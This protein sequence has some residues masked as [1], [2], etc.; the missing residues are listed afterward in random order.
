MPP[1]TKI[2]LSDKE[3]SLITNSEWI[4]T[5]Q[6]VIQKVYELLAGCSQYIEAAIMDKIF[7]PAEITATTPKIY[8]GENYRQLPY[9]LL[10]YPR[11][12]QQEETFAIRTM[13]WWAN[14]FSITLLVSGK[15]KN[16]INPEALNKTIPW[17]EDLFICVHEDQWQHHF[18]AD[19]YLP[20]H[21]LTKQQQQ[22]LLYSRS[23]IKLSV[24]YTLDQWN[25]MPE[26]LADGYLKMASLLI[27][28]PGGEKVP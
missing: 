21:H 28:C 1:I 16:L 26:L 7:L 24:K 5:K 19:N 23:F 8:K 12:F 10:D 6:S 15:F 11:Y 4:L 9:V 20:Y 17:Q 14:F 2:V 18:E 25:T 13:F 3:L 22:E 27:N